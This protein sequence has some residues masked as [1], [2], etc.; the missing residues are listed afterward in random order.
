MDY[1]SPG[2]EHATA[3]V[4]RETALLLNMMILF[5]VV[6]LWNVVLSFV[7]S[8][9]PLRLSKKRYFPLACRFEEPATFERIRAEAVSYLD[10]HRAPCVHEI[11]P[12]L[13]ISSPRPP[14]GRDLCW[15][16][17]A[18]KRRGVL[19]ESLRAEMPTLVRLLEHPSIANASLSS[20]DPGREI[21][22]HRGYNKGYV[23][24]HLGL[25]VPTDAEAFIVCGGVRYAWRVGQGVLLDDMFLHRV[26]N[27]S[28]TQRRTVLFLDVRR[29]DLPPVF[30]ELTD[31]LNRLI[32]VNPLIQYAVADQH[33]PRSRS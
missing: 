24:Y 23:R 28:P 9:P 26:C 10:R 6:N 31:W 29:R 22:P 5:P 3:G 13:A 18:L 1:D 16:W 25:E 19:T 30:A 33:Q 8:N 11:A 15:R 21:P 12:L 27:P 32:D 7:C 2:P 4:N 14:D 17:V 20:L